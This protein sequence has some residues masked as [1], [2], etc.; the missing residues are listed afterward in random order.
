MQSQST[1]HQQPIIS[2]TGI[3]F[4][5]GYAT[6][7]RVERGHLAVTSGHG[8]SIREDRFARVSRPRIRRVLIYGKGGYTTWS[9]L[10]W[11]E[12]IG[13]SFAFIS[14][15]G[16]VI[17]SS[18]EAGP[19]Q[20]S[21][22]RAQVAAEGSATGLGIVIDLLTAKL[23]GQLSL[24]RRALPHQGSVIATVELALSTLES[25]DSV[26]AALSLEA[27]AAA[28][29]WGAWREVP[30]RFARVDQ[31]RIPALWS[32]VAERQSPLSTSPR[33]AVT[34][35]GATLNYL[36]ALAEVECRLALL[37]VGL[38]PG[39]GWAHRDTPYRD[40]AALDLLEV[41]R[42]EVDDYLMRMLETRT[43]SRRD[44]AEL[45]SGQVRLMPELAR[46]LAMTL[47]TWERIAS[48]GARRIAEHL[49]RSSR[50][51]V[52]IPGATSR[53]A[54]GKG[55]TTMGRGVGKATGGTRLVPNACR[56]CGLILDNRDRQYCDECLPSFKADRTTKLV[57]AARDVLTQMRASGDDPARTPEAVAKRVAAHAEQRKKALA[58]DANNPGPHNSDAFRRDVLPALANITLPQMMKATGLSSA[59]CWR[60]RRGERIPHPMHWE[61]LLQLARGVS[62]SSS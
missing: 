9:A 54:K 53:G 23:Q 4:V 28:A 45:P 41:L 19:N 3:L 48:Q 27:K 7:L 20:P 39:L 33:K 60:I 29:Y 55:R 6:A 22:R 50:S 32:T 30:M 57:A 62:P 17:A 34:S 36:Y 16:R 8:R 44:F 11:I 21:L 52:R 42:P 14:R 61:P 46:S 49:A 25:V 15:D 2:D 37:A 12:A 5:T 40:S 58:W 43:F 59:Y 1:A 31:S 38:D 51:N 13:A 26:Q 24:L 35:A 56:E 10:E 47:P 18:G